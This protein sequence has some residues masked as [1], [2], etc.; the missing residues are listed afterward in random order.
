L[1]FNTVGIKKAENQN[2]KAIFEEIQGWL[3]R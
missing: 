1:M 2:L 3:L